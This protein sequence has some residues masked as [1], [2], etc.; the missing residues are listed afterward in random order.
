MADRT[1]PKP[2]TRPAGKR[3]RIKYRQMGFKLTDGQKK[4]LEHYCKV[5]KVTPV[6]FIK[7]LVNNHVARY[8]PGDPPPSY[9]TENQLDLFEEDDMQD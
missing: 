1:A 7:S 6:R 3:R 9:V 4:A 8:R 2:G 5:H